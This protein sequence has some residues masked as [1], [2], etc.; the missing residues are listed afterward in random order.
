MHFK[1]HCVGRP[2]VRQDA[3][4]RRGHRHRP[5]RRD[6]GPVVQE[7]APGR[8]AGLSCGAGATRAWGSLPK[9]HMP[10]G[11]DAVES[12]GWDV[13]YYMTCVYERHRNAEALKTLLSPGAQAGGR[14]LPAPGPA[15]L[16][17]GRASDGQAVPGVQDPGSRAAVGTTRVGRAGLPR[18]PG[19]DQAVRRRHRGHL[20]IAT[21]TSPP[22]TPP[23]CGASAQALPAPERPY[24]AVRMVAL[25][26]AK[27]LAVHSDHGEVSRLAAACCGSLEMTA[28]ARR[29]E[30]TR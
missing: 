8:D 24:T 18:D 21:A 13:D 22:R 30:P 1:S 10:D 3:G 12:K 25:S 5:S 17:Q 29:P 11:V 4:R 28:H 2:L 9:T 16:V 26:K 7:R 20:S 14:S 23:W 19:L 6:H 27:G 15:A